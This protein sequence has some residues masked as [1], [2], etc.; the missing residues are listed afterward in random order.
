MADQTTLS[1]PSQRSRVTKRKAL[2]L[3]PPPVGTKEDRRFHDIVD[4]LLAELGQAHPTDHQF[5]CVRTAAMAQCRK[6]ALE[7]D[8]CAGR[9]FNDAIYTRIVAVQRQARE[10]LDLG[11]KGTDPGDEPEAP[12]VGDMLAQA[13]KALPPSAA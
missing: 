8:H 10:D 1:P 12:D 4:S 9:P 3:S 7:A 5:S 6:E 11:G 13:G 2:H